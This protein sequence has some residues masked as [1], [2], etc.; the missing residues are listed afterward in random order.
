MLEGLSPHKNAF[1]DNGHESF[2]CSVNVAIY[3]ASQHFGGEQWNSKFVHHNTTGNRPVRCTPVLPVITRWGSHYDCI[4]RLVA[5]KDALNGVI[6]RLIREHGQGRAAVVHGSKYKPF[7]DTM[8]A[9]E[10]HW[11]SHGK[12][13]VRWSSC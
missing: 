11:V 7:I 4:L 9:I 2:P 10:H 13:S 6:T 12:L 5:L 3:D 8:Q 1:M